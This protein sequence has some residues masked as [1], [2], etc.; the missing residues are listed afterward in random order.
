MT[1]KLAKTGMTVTTDVGNSNDIHPTNKKEVGKRL[2]LNALKVAYHNPKT[3]QSPLFKSVQFT[4]NQA[5]IAFKNL[6]SNLIMKG[7]ELKGFEIAGKDKKFYYAKAKIEGN[8]VI[9]SHSKVN[10]PVYVRYGWSNA[11]VDANLFNQEGLPASPFRTDSWEGV[12]IKK[13]Y[14]Q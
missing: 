7:S 1:L 13:Q 10:N 9:V 6:G 4:K 8:T 14:E 11:P 3:I 5:V 2:A 12:T